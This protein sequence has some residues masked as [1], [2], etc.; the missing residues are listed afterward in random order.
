[1]RKLSLL[2]LVPLLAIT[3]ALPAQARD[4]GHRRD[5][6]S[7][8]GHEDWRDDHHDNRNRHPG[9]ERDDHRDG[10]WYHGKHSGRVGWWWVVGDSWMFHSTPVYPMPPRVVVMPQRPVY[11][12]PE[13][14]YPVVMR[15]SYDLRSADDR[16]LNALAAEFQDINLRSRNARRELRDVEAR[17]EDF[18]QTLYG[19]DYN[20]MD[21][22][23]DAEDLQRRIERVREGL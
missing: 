15:P 2:L 4:G 17:V 5:D 18:R 22:L 9:P 1:M 14:M 10:R 3:A 16:A 11:V 8:Y 19:R 20:A 12:R 23:R 6:R 7:G 13:P 21:I